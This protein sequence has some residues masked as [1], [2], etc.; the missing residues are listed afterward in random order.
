MNSI[1]IELKAV[2][3]LVSDIPK[4]K[5]KKKPACEKV[6]VAFLFFTSLKKRKKI[7]EMELRGECCLD[8]VVA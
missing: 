1:L 5:N 7:K 8:A 6:G 2:H 3:F 4:T